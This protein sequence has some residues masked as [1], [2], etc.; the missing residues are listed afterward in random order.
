MRPQRIGDGWMRASAPRYPEIGRLFSL[1]GLSECGKSFAGQHFASHGVLRIKIARV[2]ADVGR[3]L[4]LD[5]DDPTFTDHLYSRHVSTALPLF[6]ERVAHLMVEKGAQRA[7]LESMYRPQMAVFLK[8]TLGPRM[9]HIFIEAPLDLRIEHAWRK[10]QKGSREDLALRIR[11]K[12]DMKRRL[13][14]PQLR[15]M[16]DVVLDNSGTLQDYQCRLDE[17]LDQFPPISAS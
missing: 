11:E 4:L 10:M 17:V 14:V 13:G 3:H 7:S 8:E 6:L 16:A 9:V 2:L 12:D 1:G 15:A 5:P